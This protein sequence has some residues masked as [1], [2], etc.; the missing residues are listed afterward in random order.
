MTGKRMAEKSTLKRIFRDK[1]E[2]EIGFVYLLEQA[3]VTW[4]IDKIDIQK[5]LLHN[6]KGGP[7]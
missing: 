2:S 4:G 1:S 3:Q 5:V 6:L 7:F